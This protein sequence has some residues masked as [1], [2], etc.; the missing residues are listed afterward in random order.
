MDRAYRETGMS[1]T[2]VGMVFIEKGMSLSL[3]LV[4]RACLEIGVMDCN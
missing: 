1:W 2:L 4:D 3:K